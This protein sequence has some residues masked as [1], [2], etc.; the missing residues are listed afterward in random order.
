MIQGWAGSPGPEFGNP[1]VFG[2]PDPGGPKIL[3]PIPDGPKSSNP[4]PGQIL[5]GIRFQNKQNSRF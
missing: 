2:D 5:P 4:D 1:G 3:I